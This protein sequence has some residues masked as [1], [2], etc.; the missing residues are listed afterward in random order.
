MRKLTEKEIARLLAARATPEPPSGLADRIKAEIP[1]SIRIERRPLQ[2]GRRWLLPPLVEGLQP[3]WLAAA[4]I[5]MVLGVGIVAARIPAQPDDVWK[6]MALSGVVHIDDVVVTAP[7]PLEPARTLVAAAPAP[8]P[9]RQRAAA[10]LKG[11]AA[12]PEATDALEA[13]AGDA[14]A[15]AEAAFSAAAASEPAVGALE[16]NVSAGHAALAGA[17]V[18]ALRADAPDAGPH[19]S[20]SDARG[21]VAM[22]D[23]PPGE[24]RVRSERPGFEPLDATVTVAAGGRARVDFAMPQSAPRPVVAAAA[25]VETT[26]RPARVASP[27]AVRAAAAPAERES[28]VTVVVLGPSGEPLEGATVTLERVGQGAMWTRTARTQADGAA[29]FRGV[30]PST[31]RALVVAED[32][33]PA[34]LVVSVTSDRE[35]TRAEIRLRPLARR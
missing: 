3:T 29:T 21:H 8:R 26:Q 19:T 6:W 16:V 31:Y 12:R 10:S 25:D 4:S 9:A 22:R 18:T 2:F 20:V 7:Q 35:P 5:L 11:A 30:P 27:A 14:G 33:T 32:V 17:N 28:G 15:P 24:Y 13:P 1:G 23:L 34:Q